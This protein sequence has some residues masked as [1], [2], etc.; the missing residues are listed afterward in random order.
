MENESSLDA[1]K[2]V[3]CQQIDI[4]GRENLFIRVTL[5]V[6]PGHKTLGEVATTLFLGNHTNITVRKIMAFDDPRNNVI[7]FEWTIMGL[8]PGISAYCKWRKMSMDE[9]VV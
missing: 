4:K 6:D 8:V 9:K 3:C 7:G 5:P 2:T 1:I